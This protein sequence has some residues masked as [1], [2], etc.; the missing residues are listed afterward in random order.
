MSTTNYWMYVE[1]IGNPPQPSYI[2]MS[3]EAILAQYYEYW[4]SRLV[5]TGRADKANDP[6]ACI[7][8][9]ILAYWAIPAT[10]ENFDRLTGGLSE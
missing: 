9:W 10:K 3:E 1:P 4:Q 2:I 6:R 8:D 5:V 7:Q